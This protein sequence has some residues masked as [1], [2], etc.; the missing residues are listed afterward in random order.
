MEKKM[1]SLADLD[2]TS[3]SSEAFEFEY[4][5]AKG[6]STGVFLRILGSQSEAVT[7][8]VAKLVNARRRKEAAREVQRSVG[9]G[10]KQVEFETLESDV[11][12][13][14]RLA[15]V[16]LVG[17]RGI[18]DAWSEANALKLCQSNRELA[19]QIVQQSEDMS[20]FMRG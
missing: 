2:A 19:A 5:T 8:E 13:G 14:Q 18:S 1:L 16:R 20:N 15:A 3:A 11:E 17:W 9:V 6:D 4:L 10:R 7:S 12:F